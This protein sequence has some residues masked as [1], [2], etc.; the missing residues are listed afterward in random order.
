MI[1]IELPDG[2][3]RTVKIGLFKALDGWEIQAKFL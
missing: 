1:S 2:S 3:N